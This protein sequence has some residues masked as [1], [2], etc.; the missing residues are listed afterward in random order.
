MRNTD[1]INGLMV[2]LKDAALSKQWVRLQD[3]DRRIAE[4]LTLLNQDKPL[5]KEMLSAIAKL[6]HIYA[7]TYESCRREHQQLAQKMA[8]LRDNRE[9]MAAYGAFETAE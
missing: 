3:V 5:N 1:L 6:Q 2:E 9:G 4:Q 8:E 7:K